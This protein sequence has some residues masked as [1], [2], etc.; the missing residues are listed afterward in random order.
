[1]AVGSGD[2]SGESAQEIEGLEHER[3]RTLG[4]GPGPAQVIDD[5]AVGAP[6]EAPSSKGRAQAVAAQ[7]FEPEPIAGGDGVGGVKGEAGDL[8]AERLGF[9]LP[10]RRKREL[11]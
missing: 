3:G 2:Q 9:G 4:V 5:A 6:C 7:S 11:G 1:M 8:G 10:V